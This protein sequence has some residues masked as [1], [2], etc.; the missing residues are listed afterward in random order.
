MKAPPQIIIT[1]D[2]QETLHN[3]FL[4]ID[5]RRV[6]I[7]YP[8]GHP[9]QTA[10]VDSVIRKAY[11][12]VAVFAHFELNRVRYV[13]LRSCLR[14]ALMFRN[15]KF[16]SG[17]EENVYINGELVDIGN[18]WECAAGLI[19]KDEVGYNGA[20]KAACRE[21][22]EEV[23]ILVQPDE[24]HILGPRC[25]S[26]VGMV[27]ERIYFFETE[28]N[29]T[30]QETPGEDGGPF[31]MCGITYAIPLKE[32]LREIETGIILDSKTQMGLMRLAKKFNI[33]Y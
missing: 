8:E 18:T 23:G 27:A 22:Y 7:K 21:L 2:S 16:D 6:T 33:E 1:T 32:A 4:G 24:M 31:E 10:T 28:V 3:G 15:Y 26:C 30:T 19:D 25:F 14:P 20:Y 29:P 12:A 13:Y 5:R 11:D 9:D 17:R